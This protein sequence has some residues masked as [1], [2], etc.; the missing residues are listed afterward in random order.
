M[1]N[2]YGCTFKPSITTV[3]G[4][5]TK[6]EPK[7]KLFE[8][9]YKDHEKRLEKLGNSKTKL[10]VGCTFSP[11]VTLSKS[12]FGNNGQV[13][14]TRKVV[15]P[16]KLMT[17]GTKACPSDQRRIIS[18]NA[19]THLAAA[20]TDEKLPISFLQTVLRSQKIVKSSQLSLPGQRLCWKTLNRSLLSQLL[21]SRINQKPNQSNG[22]EPIEP[23]SSQANSGQHKNPEPVTNS[24][25]HF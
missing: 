25:S 3:S 7:K 20:Q 21:W 5:G 24:A 4:A 11:D 8:R 13:D 12:T 22:A 23:K 10:P 2:P 18:G 19:L 15:R 6:K 14:F 16:K 9:L 17:A 1:A